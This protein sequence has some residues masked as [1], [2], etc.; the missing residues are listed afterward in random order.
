MTDLTTLQRSILIALA[1]GE[2]PIKQSDLSDAIGDV[3]HE[4]TRAIKSLECRELISRSITPR[5]ASIYITN[6]GREAIAISVVC[7]SSF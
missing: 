2:V 5:H 7:R 1:E 3:G 4:F 6:R